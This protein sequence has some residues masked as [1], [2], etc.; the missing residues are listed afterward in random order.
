MRSLDV[1]VSDYVQSLSSGGQTNIWMLT[2]FCN[3]QSE[4][5][6]SHFIESK[7]LGM[8]GMMGGGVAVVHLVFPAWS[9][10]WVCKEVLAFWV[11]LKI[12]CSSLSSRPLRHFELILF[13]AHSELEKL[14]CCNRMPHQGQEECHCRSAPV[15][16]HC[17]HWF[18]IVSK[19]FFVVPPSS[20]SSRACP[21]LCY[22]AMPRGW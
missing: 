18:Q 5:D 21:A 6:I 4:S 8:M 3:P 16:V 7:M 20:V 11:S 22:L 14:R 2:S 19:F 9:V 13:Q 15:S 12:V 17:P 10:C 1:T